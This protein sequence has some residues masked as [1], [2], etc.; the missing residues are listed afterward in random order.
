MSSRCSVQTNSV[1]ER[2]EP[3][4]SISEVRGQHA[5]VRYL[6]QGYLGSPL[7][8]PQH[9]SCCLR[10]LQPPQ[11]RTQRATVAPHRLPQAWS[12]CKSRSSRL[13]RTERFQ[14]GKLGRHQAVWEAGLFPA[15]RETF[16]RRTAS[17][18]DRRSAGQPQRLRDARGR[19]RDYFPTC[20]GALRQTDASLCLTYSFYFRMSTSPRLQAANSVS[21]S[22]TVCRERKE[23]L[24]R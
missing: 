16:K 8:V 22:P 3:R 24:R 6:A 15:T 7:K 1:C 14:T 20:L 12:A 11:S 18:A 23:P 17:P 9:L 19:S 5:G 10:A 13:K 4:P 21:S 2:D